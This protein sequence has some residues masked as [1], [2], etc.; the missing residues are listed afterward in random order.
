MDKSKIKR[1]VGQCS[2]AS[3]GEVF[4]VKDS[5]GNEFIQKTVLNPIL[6]S[7]SADLRDSFKHLLQ[8][9]GLPA[10]FVRRRPERRETMR[11]L[12]QA[13]RLS[14]APGMFVMPDMNMIDGES[15]FRQAKVGREWLFEHLG[16]VPEACWIA[17]CWGHHA[18]LPQILRQS[19]YSAYFFWRCMRPDVVRSDFL[20]QGLDGTKIV[21]HWLSHGYAG[22]HFPDRVGGVE[23]R[24]ELQIAEASGRAIETLAD[25]LHACGDFGATLICNGGD[26]CVPQSGAPATLRELNRNS[27]VDLR[28]ST[29]AGYHHAVDHAR[30]ETFSGEF[31]AAFQ[32]TYS[33]NIAIKQL[34]R[35][36]REELLAEESFRATRA[37]PA[38]DL[39]GAWE[40]VLTHQFH[41]TICGT[42]TNELLSRLGPRLPIVA[43]PQTGQTGACAA[44]EFAV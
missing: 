16:V 14:F 34:L 9:T 37:L 44:A 15:L 20:W 6:R 23:N 29:P 21:T 19:G 2:A 5:Y 41:D 31:N 35:S 26:F 1:I 36:R 22:I 10:D 39:A 12:A 18:Q 27:D 11:A 38:G 24:L 7:G 3:F 13:Q 28:F 43:A 42:I 30:L 32:G 17:D 8:K 40:T 33:T 4:H 25:Q